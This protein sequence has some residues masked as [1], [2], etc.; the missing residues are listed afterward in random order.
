MSVPVLQ[1]FH[2]SVNQRNNNMERTAVSS[3]NLRSIG[4]EQEGST[5][6]VEFN[7]GA[8]YL[9]HGVPQ[10]VFD[11]LMQAGSKGAYFNANIKNKYGTTKL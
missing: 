1:S 6:E 5:L 4:Y 11:S 2:Q 7:T 3:S 8:V 9:Y 10:G